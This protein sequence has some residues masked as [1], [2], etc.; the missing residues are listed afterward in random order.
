MF[1]GPTSPAIK[2]RIHLVDA[3]RGFALAGIV[4]V[5]FMEQYLGNMPPEGHRNYTQQWPLDR[6]LEGLAFVFIRGKGFALF[7]FMFGL[8]FALQMERAAA[9]APDRDFRPRFAWRLMILLGIGFFHSLI[10]RGD[11]LMV[12]C[13]L[14]LPLMLFYHVPDRWLWT[15][16]LLLM[17]GL[18]RVS[19]HWLASGSSQQDAASAALMNEQQ[20]KRHYHALATGAVMDM[21]SN[22]AT[23]GFTNRMN[24][25]F[26]PIARG[27]QT[28]AYFLLGLWAGR[29][30]LFAEIE[31]H[32]PFIHKMFK[33][34][35]L[36]TL[37]IPLAA[38]L[39]WWIS[40][41]A[42]AGGQPAGP[43]SGMPTLT[44]W[45]MILGLGLYDLWNMIMTFF[46]IAAFILLFQRPGAR[47]YLIH[48]APV[49]QMALTSYVLQSIIGGLV[50]FGY[51]LGL[52]GKVGNTVSLSIALVVFGSQIW[53][54]QW[55]LRH[56][57]FGP[58]E[59]LWR[60]LTYLRRQ[61]F[62]IVSVPSQP[63]PVA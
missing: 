39:L 29:R 23:E 7:S 17:L 21:I 55:W 6:L 46:Y 47:R 36:L 3:M 19:M 28:F 44:S 8:S 16:A 62:R 30:R 13:L 9:R 12:Y 48:L 42:G 4:M 38:G 51:G 33:W 22:N 24:F 20:A 53:F 41:A 15:V 60:S 50:F 27:Y 11:I 31:A 34:C 49:G 59:W 58:L 57:R 61:P 40:R 10:Y 56:F 35:G 52:L 26:G 37:A 63:A 54:C 45:P 5:H 2:N 25:Q 14:G 32:Q 18:P 43:P 1:S